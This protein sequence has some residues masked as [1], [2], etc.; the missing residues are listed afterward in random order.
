MKR[1]TL[2]IERDI[3][4]QEVIVTPY[5]GKAVLMIPQLNKGTA[6]NQSERDEL[7]LNG[8]LPLNIETIEQQLSRVYHQL[9]SF[10]TDIQKSVYFRTTRILG[11]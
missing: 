2:K 10:E 9:E 1:N 5:S 4:G 3:D 6:F 7:A 11:R 8:K